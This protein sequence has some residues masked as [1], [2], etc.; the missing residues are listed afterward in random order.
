MYDALTGRYT[1]TCPH[2]GEARVTLSAFRRLERLPGA[3]HPAVYGVRFSC[4]CG[5]EHPGLVSDDDLDWAPLGLGDARRFLNVMTATLD[6]LA[7][8]LVDLT[9]RRIGAGEWPWTFFC[10]PEERPRPVF[11]SS[12]FLLAPGGRS[13]G[14]AV[15][16]PVCTHVSVNLVSAHHVDVPFHHDREVGVVPHVFADD[17]DALVAEFSA[18][19]HSARFDARRL[20]LE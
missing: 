13:I 8:E 15:R 1:F 12:F 10:Y 18:E 17:A 6:R 2:G 16:C 4:R 5:D 3:A 11:P 14:L 9:A 19:L 20:D 7:D